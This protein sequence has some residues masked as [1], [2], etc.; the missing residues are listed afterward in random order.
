MPKK[1]DIST[2]V[3]NLRDIDACGP[4]VINVSYYSSLK[5]LYGHFN[6]AD[7]AVWFYARVKGRARTLTLF[8][9]LLL[10]AAK[11]L[12]SKKK[13]AK[14]CRLGSAKIAK[15]MLDHELVLQEYYLVF[16]AIL[17]LVEALEYSRL[18]ALHSYWAAIYMIRQNLVSAD[19]IIRRVKKL[20]PYSEFVKIASGGKHVRYRSKKV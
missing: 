11:T 6:R 16:T 3:N 9:P 2:F 17:D 10:M 8:R 15:A 19:D 18:V 20:L 12:V 7:Y 4:A 1:N 5:E 14:I 13:Y